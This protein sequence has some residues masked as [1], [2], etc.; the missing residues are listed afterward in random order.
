MKSE[1]IIH[2]I[3]SIDPST[4]FLF[5]VISSLGHLNI[6]LIKIEPSDKSYKEGVE[7]ISKISKHSNII[8][9]GH[10]TSR[11]LYGG[12]SESFQ[13]K[14][15]ISIKT[16]N[17]FK[18]QN[19]F[20]LA[21]DSALLLKSAFRFS[22]IKKSIGFGSLPT[23]IEE[24]ENDKKL[25]KSGITDEIIEEYKKEIVDVVSS[26]FNYLYQNTNIDFIVLKDYIDLLLL[27]KINKTVL[28]YNNPL[29]ADLLHKMKKEMVIY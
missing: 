24:I 20:L 8:F 19:I 15:L 4:E 16:M 18:N 13:K 25:S 21:C 12:E 27:K 3:V 7:N 22:Q 1:A 23:S 10:G 5:K 6:N 9:L 14:E 28:E 17:I 29:L 11:I 26:A 2:I